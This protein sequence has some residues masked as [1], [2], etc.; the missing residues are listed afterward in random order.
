MRT[1]TILKFANERV[2]RYTSYPTAPHF[3]STINGSTYGRWLTELDRSKPV[4]LYLHVPFCR[5][6]CWYCG[7][8]TRATRQNE[9][10]E[11]YAD[12]LLKEIDIVAA[13]AGGRLEVSHVHWGGGSPT[14]LPADRFAGLMDHIRQ[15]FDVLSDA[16]IAV[17]VDP[18]IFDAAMQ[19]AFISAGV[20]R[21]SLGIQ[22]FDDTV[23]RAV[24][25][26]QPP[27]VVEE[28]VDM[29][30]DAGV[31]G[32]NFDLIY[33][34]PLQ[35]TENCV[36]TARTALH[37]DP[38]RFSVFGYAH[39]PHMKPHQKMIDEAD[40]PDATAR[41]AQA[42]AIADVLTS[43]DH[44]AVG[45]D[46]FARSGDALAKAQHKG[47]LRRNFQ[48]Y[49]TDTASAII[50]L[51]ASAIGRLPQGY[52]QHTSSTHEWERRVREGE[53]PTAR[54]YRLTTEDRLRSD[55]IEELMCTLSVDPEL[56]A[57]RHE[58][59]MPRPDLDAFEAAGVVIRD[60]SRIIVP[61]QYRALVRSVAAAFD[62]YLAN[63][64]ARHS[65]AV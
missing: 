22:T 63:S 19:G 25:R 64:A 62:G 27:E 42:D 65:V 33:G 37:F 2:P 61:P 3:S 38:D 5:A 59:D 57:V 49:T 46:H 28:C 11:R 9:P 4:S 6:M 26:I 17:E 35:T 60:G 8:H 55:I 47:T 56:H 48:G 18:R 36:S 10:V 44:V 12:A 16:E 41:L 24:N 52:V 50:G 30:R 15:R 14:Y 32:L 13:S 45:M 53:L 20:T 40:L 31:T 58:R 54:G 43:H 21:A 29:L 39:V 7:C 23:Q 34:L 1:D 51:G